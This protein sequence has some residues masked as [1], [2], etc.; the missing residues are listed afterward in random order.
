MAKIKKKMMQKPAPGQD[1][2]NDI[3][4]EKIGSKEPKVQ[5]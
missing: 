4:D 5:W 2:S 3:K 1:L